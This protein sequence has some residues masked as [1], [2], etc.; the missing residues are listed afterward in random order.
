MKIA[1][2]TFLVTGGASG[3]GEATV[4]KIVQQ[5]GNAVI[6]DMNEQ[7][8]QEVATE[9]GQSSVLFVKTN[10]VSE[11]DVSKA[12][13]ATV[14]KFGGIHGVIN[15]AGVASAIRVV[16]KNGAHPLAEFNKVLSINLTGTFNVL[17]LA[18][19]YMSKQEPVNA[20]GERGVIINTASVAAFEGQIGQAAYSASKGAVFAMTLPISRELSAFGIR[21]LCIAP[22]TF[23]TP[24]LKSLPQKAR[25][26]LATQV[27]FPKRLGD[28]SEFAHLVAHMIE[29]PMLNGEC[30]RIDGS[31]RMSAM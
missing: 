8:G 3:L 16:G 28:P 1:G 14:S 27:P 22:G 31:I 17:R 26:S 9:L 19:A 7:R 21:C 2:H 5:G 29:N 12:I 18:A 4:R 10:I 25:D 20:D 11:E 24:M 6:L 23:D 13:S 30:V 15:C